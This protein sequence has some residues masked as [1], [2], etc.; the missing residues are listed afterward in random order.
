MTPE[1][2]KLFPLIEFILC[3]VIFTK[4]R[5][6]PLHKVD[7]MGRFVANCIKKYI[8]KVFFYKVGPVMK[9]VKLNFY[10]RDIFVFIYPRN[11]SSLT[12]K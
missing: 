6:F 10:F 7:L 1:N 8:Q 11:F 3:F 12:R 5:L 9:M 2:T 4:S